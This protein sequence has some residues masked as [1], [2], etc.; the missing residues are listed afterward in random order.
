[1]RVVIISSVLNI[2]FIVTY[3]V[4]TSSVLCTRGPHA[5]D[6]EQAKCVEHPG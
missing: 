2:G 5:K 3:G 1:M 4:I 6:S